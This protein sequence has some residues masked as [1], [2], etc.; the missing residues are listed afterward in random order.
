MQFVKS[1]FAGVQGFSGRLGLVQRVLPSYR[2]PF[3][4]TLAEACS[5]G[6]SVFAGQP[7]PQESIAVTSQLRNANYV[8]AKNL[9]FLKPQS[10]LYF[11]YQRGL[12]RWLEDWN[13]DSLII[14]ANFRYL[15]STAAIRWMHKRNRPVIGWG[16]GA[17]LD[18]G[19]L[20]RLRQGFLRQFDAMIAYS[21]RGAEQYA[22]CGCPV[23]KIF[24]AP[25]SV[26]P[27][28]KHPLPARVDFSTPQPVVLFVGRLQARKRI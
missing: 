23:D 19:P 16:L 7:L 12:I 6:L 1:D 25:N 24:V 15:S 20:S 2:A 28:P 5:G 17:P 8:P 27:A 10:P 21:A 14:E 4:D 18:R 22:A 9:H 26:A 13:P 11:C 3:F